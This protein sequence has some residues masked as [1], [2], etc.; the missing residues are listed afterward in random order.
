MENVTVL[1]GR[2][3]TVHQQ[4]AGIEE[5]LMDLSSHFVE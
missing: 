1:R 5:K 3:Q 2:P 4:F